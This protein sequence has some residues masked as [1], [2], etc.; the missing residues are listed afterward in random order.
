MKKLILVAL[1]LITGASFVAISAKDTKEQKEYKKEQ[2]KYRED[3]E[4]IAKNQAKQ[5][6][7]EKWEYSGAV[8]LELAL[9]NLYLES[10]PT[11]GGTKKNITHEV[12]NAKTISDGE[13]RLLLMA[14]SN[15]AQEVR[16]MLGSDIADQINSNSREY[17]ENYVQNIAAKVMHEFNGDITR[18]ILLKKKNRDGKTW[19]MRAYY[20]VDKEAGA[21]RSKRIADDVRNNNGIIE[22]IHNEVFGTEE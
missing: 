12:D 7:K 9:T 16:S 18:V 4:K 3:A 17:N 6:K 1:M 10:E 5:I 21:N 20:L 14:Q 15:Y 2:Q 22:D 13:R 11:M 19:T 8:P